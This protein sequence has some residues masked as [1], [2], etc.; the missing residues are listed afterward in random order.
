M[1]STT[2]FTGLGLVEDAH[3]I[4]TGIRSLN[5]VDTAL[6]GVSASLDTLALAVDPLGTLAAWGVAWLIEHVRPLQDALDWLA[7]NPAEVAAQ[8]AAWSNVA[9]LTESARLEFADRLRVEVAEWYGAS[10]DAYRAHAAEHLSMLQGISVAAS[11]ISYAVEG[12]GL[13]V[14]LVRGMVRDLTAQFVATLA[15]RLPQ[16]LAA[17]G[18]TLG[19]ATPAVVG[20]VAGLV[21]TWV[22]K[23]QHF[24]RALLDSMR[25]L[26]PE[27]DL[28][29]KT[30]GQLRMLADRLSGSHPAHPSSQDARGTA[31]GGAAEPDGG[32]KAAQ[33]ADNTP[34]AFVDNIV[35]HP[36]SLA[37]Q[38]AQ[39]I[40]DR[41]NAA[42]YTAVVEP[43]TKRGTSGNAIQVRIHGHPEITNIQVHPGGGRHTPEGSPYWKISTST[44][45]KTWVIPKD[46]RGADQLG[47][48]VVRYEE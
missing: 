21:T 18:L 20:Q 35:S 47:G 12:A 28:L 14:S 38:S 26:L 25:R 45:G 4:V 23:I 46:F 22:N 39:D 17:E 48:N 40:A 42:G 19:L 2:T 41:F 31:S 15:V 8:A 10:G 3:Q 36:T 33:A 34:R 5:W 30:L 43:S 11:G 32:P 27:V 37:G 13:L 29:S 16:W 6:G 44:A 1:D 9:A 7:G 24:L